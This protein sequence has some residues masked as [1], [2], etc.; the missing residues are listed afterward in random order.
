M[1]SQ[2]QAFIEYDAED[3]HAFIAYLDREGGRDERVVADPVEVAPYLAP[4]QSG[5]I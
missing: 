3:E 1:V 4:P 2:Q 5:K